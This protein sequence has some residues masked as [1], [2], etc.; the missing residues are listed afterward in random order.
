M[1]QLQ[2]EKLNQQEAVRVLDQLSAR[3]DAIVF[4]RAV[5]EVSKRNLSFY[6]RYR[7]CRLINFATMPTFSMTY[8]TDGTDF[9]GI[10]GTPGLIYAVNR[11][12]PIA[13]TEANVVDYIEFFFSSVQGLD[14]DV[15]LIK[16][17]KHMPFMDILTPEQRQGFTGCFQ[18]VRIS[19]DSTGTFEVNA[20]VYYG[21]GLI[22]AVV[23]VTPEGKISFHDQS[24]L[25]SG[26]HFPHN[27]H[28]Q[29]WLE[30]Q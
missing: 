30:G 13:L 3:P 11:K 24:L 17:P 1:A 18:P 27:P 10:D 16:D 23:Q 7:L 4:S 22:K 15:F 12:D 28:S 14:G 20:T 29:S 25:L 9:I 8:L 6:S 5:T 19:T 2:W 21:G 26:I